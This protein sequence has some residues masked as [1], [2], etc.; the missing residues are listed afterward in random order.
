VNFEPITLKT[1]KKKRV[2][3]GS[4]PVLPVSHHKTGHHFWVIYILEKSTIHDL[5]FQI[6]QGYKAQ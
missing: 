4:E 2:K 5:I 1:Q 3:P 6:L